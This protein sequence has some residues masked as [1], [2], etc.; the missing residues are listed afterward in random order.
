VFVLVPTISGCFG[1]NNLS[2]G[3]PGTGH[4]FRPRWF[5]PI[6]TLEMLC[7]ICPYDLM[8][9][10]RFCIHRERLNRNFKRPAEGKRSPDKVGCGFRQLATLSR[11]RRFVPLVSSCS[12]RTSASG[13]RKGR[14]PLGPSAPHL[15][16][17]CLPTLFPTI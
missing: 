1:L 6:M 10:L 11:P 2:C 5:L 8:L 14:L 4:N 13:E 9:G 7:P 3:F 12:A 16:P 15:F 17:D